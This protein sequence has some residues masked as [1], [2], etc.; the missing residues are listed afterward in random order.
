[1]DDGVLPVDDG[2]LLESDDVGSGFD[3]LEQLFD[4]VSTDGVVIIAES[5]VLAAGYIKQGLA[6]CSDR[7]G[8]VV[9]EHE[10]LHGTVADLV[11]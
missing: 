2:H 9:A 5:D 3:G 10:M 8:S 7:S 1:M 6:L 11:R 4:V